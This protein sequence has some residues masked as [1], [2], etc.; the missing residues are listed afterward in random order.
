V[1][2]GRS[3]EDRTEAKRTLELYFFV[4]TILFTPKV[5]RPASK[6]ACLWEKNTMGFSTSTWMLPYPSLGTKINAFPLSFKK[7]ARRYAC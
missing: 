5:P 7:L 1:I 3:A 4:S 6:A 2:G